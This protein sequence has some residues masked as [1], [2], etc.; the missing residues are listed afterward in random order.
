M[1]W[2]IALL[3]LACGLIAT[4]TLSRLVGLALTVRGVLLKFLLSM[5]AGACIA[6]AVIWVLSTAACQPSAPC[7]YGGFM[8][9]GA[10]IALIWLV[11]YSVAY[12]LVGY[13]L[14]RHRSRKQRIA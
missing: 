5:V 11:V 10:V 2:K 8:E 6:S 1:L 3:F 7:E 12:V 9:G 14:A 13:M 4:L